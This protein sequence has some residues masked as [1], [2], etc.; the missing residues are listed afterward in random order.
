MGDCPVSHRRVE[1]DGLVAEAGATYHGGVL[2]CSGNESKVT[3]YDGIDASADD[4][5]DFFY[6]SDNGGDHHW[7]EGGIAVRRGLYVDIGD[8]VTEFSI[9]LK[10][11]PRETG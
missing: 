7:L 1:V 5:I 2:V 11:P 8:R 9:Y 4:V 6:G 10:P 3:V